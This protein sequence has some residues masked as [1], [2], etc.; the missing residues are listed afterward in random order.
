MDHYKPTLLPAK[1]NFFRSVP[2]PVVDIMLQ[3]KGTSTDLPNSSR[4]LS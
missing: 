1:E 4:H 3:N 2:Y